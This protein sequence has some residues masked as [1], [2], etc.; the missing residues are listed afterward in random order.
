MA[1]VTPVRIAA[2][3][4]AAVAGFYPAGAAAARGEWSAHLFDGR[5]EAP[6]VR[7]PRPPAG[8]TPVGILVPHAGLVYSG[9]AAAAGWC[10]ASGGRTRRRGRRITDRRSPRHEPPG[11]LAGRCRRAGTPAHGAPRSGTRSSTSRLRRESSALGPAVHRRPRRRTSASIR[12]RSSCR[13]CRPSSRRPGSCRWR[14]RAGPAPSAVEA[15]TR[16]G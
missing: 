11:R 2:G 1:G 8:S 10:R 3:P 16:L 12:S 6:G 15:G 13:C 5:G 4:P 9:V 7:A 14:S